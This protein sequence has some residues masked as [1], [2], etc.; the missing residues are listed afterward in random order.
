MSAT[1]MGPPLPVVWIVGA[2]EL[3]YR[4]HDL[5]KT[6]AG[7]AHIQSGHTPNRAG[8]GHEVAGLRIGNLPLER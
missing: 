6:P 5:F 4:V 2:L 8:D 7:R 3:A 1:H